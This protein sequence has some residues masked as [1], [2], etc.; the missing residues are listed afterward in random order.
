MNIFASFKCPVK[1]AKVL[2]DK[3]IVKMVLESAQIMSTV[4]SLRADKKDAGPYK[5]THIGHPVVKWAA[6]NQENYLWLYKHFIALCE[7]YKKR[8]GKTHKCYQY[9]TDFDKLS[10][11]LPYNSYL[12]P[13]KRAN[14][15]QPKYFVNCTEFKELPVHLA[16]KLQLVKK[17]L[18]DIRR[19]TWDKK[20]NINNI[21]EYMGGDYENNFNDI[22]L[23]NLS[24]LRKQG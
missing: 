18:N 3:R 13:Y 22:I 14:D 10:Y 16:Y 6:E 12:L 21:I 17:W 19:P 20:E 24:R 11:L 23:N 15:G 1:S 7:E 5:P 8:Y 2:D 4:V 9:A